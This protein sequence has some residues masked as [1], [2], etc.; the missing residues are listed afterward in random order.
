MHTTF[1]SLPSSLLKPLPKPT[2]LSG[3]AIEDTVKLLQ[4]GLE[5]DDKVEIGR[6]L[7]VSLLGLTT[8][9]LTI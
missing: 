3:T 1:D 8:L 5:N 6:Y 4:R 2:T 7:G 9:Q